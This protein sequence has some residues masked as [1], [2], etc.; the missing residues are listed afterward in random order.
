MKI[1]IAPVTA[2]PAWGSDITIVPGEAFSPENIEIDGANITDLIH[3]LRSYSA[4]FLDRGNRTHTLS[5]TFTS[6][7]ASFLLSE[8]ALILYANSLPSFGLVKFYGETALTSVFAYMIAGLRDFKM[9]QI[10]VASIRSFT[11]VGGALSTTTLPAPA[12]FP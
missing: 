7:N 5:F 11:L 10:G 12:V 2:G 3:P 4:V 6:E 1:T 8:T 9:K